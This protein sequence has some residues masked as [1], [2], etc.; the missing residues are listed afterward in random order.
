[1]PVTINGKVV[2]Q[3][4]AGTLLFYDGTEDAPDTMVYLRA[5]DGTWQV[6]FDN[7]DKPTGSATADDDLDAA[8]ASGAFKPINKAAE[9]YV[10]KVAG[11]PEPAAPEAPP[12]PTQAEQLK[13]LLIHGAVKPSSEAGG[14]SSEDW[15]LVTTLKKA[16]TA[17]TDRWALKN[18]DHWVSY[19][20]QPYAENAE[21]YHVSPDLAVT[22]HLAD[23]TDVP[24]PAEKLSALV[25][26]LVV[27]DAVKINMGGKH[28]GD[29]SD[30]KIFKFGFYYKP[31]KAAK[32]YIEISGPQEGGTKV[33]FVYHA[34]SGTKNVNATYAAKVLADATDYHEQ[35]KGAAPSSSKIAYA[36]MLKTGASLSA[37]VRC[38]Q[39]PES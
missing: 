20:Y 3:A 26:Q 11:K 8:V 19:S 21:Y 27:P 2:Y 9:Q 14:K 1:M 32:A 13:H 25:Q 31:S 12:E 15:M 6:M 10:A 29:P 36:T 4:P 30:Y 37:L 33:A 39:G 24:V 35:P 7:K 34:P 5:P 17:G 18:G 38:R 16:A 23:G 28:Y 22:H